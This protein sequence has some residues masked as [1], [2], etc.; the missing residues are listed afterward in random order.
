MYEVVRRCGIT[1][2][3]GV[4]TARLQ[5][6]TTL[7]LM[8][9]LVK[10]IEFP[11]RPSQ[12]LHK[13]NHRYFMQTRP[14]HHQSRCP[15]YI[16]MQTPHR[17]ISARGRRKRASRSHFISLAFDTRLNAVALCLSFLLPVTQHP[18]ERRWQEDLIV[19]RC[20]LG[21]VVV[22]ASAFGLAGPYTAK[23]VPAK[24]ERTEDPSRRLVI[25]PASFFIANAGLTNPTT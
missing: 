11:H 20:C 15:S 18:R 24:T 19:A 12:N 2:T 17:F 22:L 5:E 6:R 14:S 8:S 9:R 1:Q 10:R 16:A 3:G 13:E 7:R 21:N 25:Y 23:S 4:L